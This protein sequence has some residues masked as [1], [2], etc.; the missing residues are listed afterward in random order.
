MECTEAATG[1]GV[2]GFEHMLAANMPSALRAFEDIR[3]HLEQIQHQVFVSPEALHTMSGA[4][5]DNCMGASL[6]SV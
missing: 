2:Q 6:E 5:L 4:V 3:G 1:Q